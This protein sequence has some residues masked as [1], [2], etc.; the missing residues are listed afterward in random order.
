MPNPQLPMTTVVTPCHEEGV[1][2]DEPRGQHQ[3]VKV[4]DVAVPVSGRAARRLDRGDP[5][6]V[7]DHIGRPGRPG[8]VHQQHSG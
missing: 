3:A 5:V 1:A 7:D 6:R 2:V 8:P 4:N